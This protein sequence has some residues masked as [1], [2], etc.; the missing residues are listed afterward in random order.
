MNSY[1]AES[2]YF[3]SAKSLTILVTGAEWLD[4]ADGKSRLDLRTGRIDKLPEGVSFHSARKTGDTWEVEFLLTER[5]E[6]HFYQAWRSTYYDAQGNSYDIRCTS[7]G[8]YSR[9]EPDG[10]FSTVEGVQRNTLYL[11]DY[12]YDEVWLCPQY[13]RLWQAEAPVALTLDLAP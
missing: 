7:S 10:S 9:Q 12:P 3:E 1:R 8:L 5:E 6:N 4:K 2:P 13:S 11:E